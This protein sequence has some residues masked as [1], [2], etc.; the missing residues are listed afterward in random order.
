MNT[1]F[2]RKIK[3]KL[4]SNCQNLKLMFPKQNKKNDSNNWITISISYKF[5]S[6][7]IQMK[8][9]MG[10]KIKHSHSSHL[11]LLWVKQQN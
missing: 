4:Y 5:I 3:T 11:V 9:D 10:K 8:L 7:G 1:C 6:V 2:L